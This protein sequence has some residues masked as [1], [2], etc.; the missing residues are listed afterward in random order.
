MAKQL[1]TTQK[2]SPPAFGKDIDGMRADITRMIDACETE[3]DRLVTLGCEALNGPHFKTGTRKMFFNRPT[4]ATGA[5]ASVYV[6]TNP[7]KQAEY[8]S[9]QYRESVRLGVATLHDRIARELDGLNRALAQLHRDYS[10]AVTTLREDVQSAIH[11]DQKYRFEVGE[12][13]DACPECEYAPR[14]VLMGNSRRLTICPDCNH[15]G[16]T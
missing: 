11:S 1:R 14:P 5:R 3:N 10:R 7:N 15:I 13:A 16:H 2:K 4:D 9:R 6:G 12:H 8:L